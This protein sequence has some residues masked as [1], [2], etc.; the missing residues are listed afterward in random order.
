M[1]APFT[2]EGAAAA[3]PAPSIPAAAP[4]AA[5]P[6][7]GSPPPVP[8][9]AFRPEEVLDPVVLRPFLDELALRAPDRAK[10]AIEQAKAGRFGEAAST[11]AVADPNGPAK[12]FLQGLSLFSQKQLQAAS[13]SFRETLRAAPDYFVGAF[14][15]GACYAAGGRDPQAVNAWQTSLVGL[16][17]YPIVFRLLADAQTRMG[18]PD[19]ALETIEEALAKWP[20]DGDVRLRAARAALDARQFDR[21]FTVVDEGLKGHAA[22]DL[23]LAGIQAAYEQVGQRSEPPA[24]EQV[25]R[26]RRYRDAYVAAGGSQQAL[27]AEWLGAIERKR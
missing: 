7:P 3:T 8:G 21:V 27:V 19:R 11:A 6:R 22:P 17:H 24:G 1:S 4:T 18:R 9:N 26:A 2:R 20:G 5:R 23:L 14:Y 10:P 13:E 12:P 16:E 15:I 25:A